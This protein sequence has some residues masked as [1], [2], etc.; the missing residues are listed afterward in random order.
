MIST[1]LFEIYEINEFI[2]SLND[3]QHQPWNSAEFAGIASNERHAVEERLGCDLQVVRTYNYPLLIQVGADF[4]IG[5]CV[6]RVEG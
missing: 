4:A 3:D 2:V 1:Y 5:M 6:A